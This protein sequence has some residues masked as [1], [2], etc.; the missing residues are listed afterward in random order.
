MAAPVLTRDPPSV[1]RVSS[2]VVSPPVWLSPGPGSPLWELSNSGM[3]APNDTSVIGDL[4]SVADSS[5]SSVRIAAATGVCVSNDFL[6][7]LH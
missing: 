2:S 5:S 4:P 7:T 6:Q 3:H 1:A